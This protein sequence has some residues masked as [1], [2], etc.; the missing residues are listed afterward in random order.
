MKIYDYD[1]YSSPDKELLDL[2]TL[3]IQDIQTF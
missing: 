3:N 2:G 1:T